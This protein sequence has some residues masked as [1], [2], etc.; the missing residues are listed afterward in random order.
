M[1]ESLSTQSL[2]KKAYVAGFMF[3]LISVELGMEVALV[4]K[5]KGGDFQVGKLNGIGG[6]IEALKDSDGCYCDGQESPVTAMVRE[7]E[8]ETGTKTNPNE[9]HNFC[10]LNGI[11][12]VVYFFKNMST[13]HYKL[14]T[15]EEEEIAWYP[16]KNL[17]NESIV[18]NLKW[19]IPLALDHHVKSATILETI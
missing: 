6:K 1:N 9:W 5:I 19:L 10:S 12:W 2:I 17:H 13:G 11:D 18:P 8:E 15:M 7:F 4:R 16:I 14:Q 3:R